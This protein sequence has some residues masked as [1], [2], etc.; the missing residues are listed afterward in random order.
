MYVHL[1]VT[2]CYTFY[3]LTLDMRCEMCTTQSKGTITNVD[4]LDNNANF[5][6]LNCIIGILLA[7]IDI[8]H[9]CNMKQYFTMMFMYAVYAMSDIYF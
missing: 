4:Q 9:I 6:I 8:G 5:I 7:V 2:N 3:I 1:N